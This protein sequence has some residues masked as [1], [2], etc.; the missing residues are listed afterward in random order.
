MC[1]SRIIKNCYIIIK[2]TLHCYCQMFT[3][4]VL[5]EV[6]PIRLMILHVNLQ[7]ITLN[8]SYNAYYTYSI[9]YT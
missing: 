5:T 4:E 9:V 3:S 6:V 8:L 7:L 2:L 1:I